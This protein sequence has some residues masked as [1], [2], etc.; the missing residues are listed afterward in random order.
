MAILQEID[1]VI[2]VVDLKF[3]NIFGK[4]KE[5]NKD[6]APVELGRYFN[7]RPVPYNTQNNKFE[8]GSVSNVILSRPDTFLSLKYPEVDIR[9]FVL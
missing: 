6:Y 7:N 1:G 4:D 8:V 9:G 5:S 3:Y 2:N